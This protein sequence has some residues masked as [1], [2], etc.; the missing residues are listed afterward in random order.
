MGEKQIYMVIV[1]VLLVFVMNSAARSSYNF[2]DGDELFDQRQ[3]LRELLES[4]MEKRNDDIEKGL[5]FLAQ[6]KADPAVKNIG[7]DYIKLGTAI[8]HYITNGD[9]ASLSEA[10]KDIEDYI[11]NLKNEPLLLQFVIHLADSLKS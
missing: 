4:A 1:M 10:R 2:Y 5:Q 7:N 3:V 11:N 9:A 8:N 6:H